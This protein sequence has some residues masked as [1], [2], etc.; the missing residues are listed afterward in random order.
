[1]AGFSKQEIIRAHEAYVATRDRIDAGQ[2]GWD[3]LGDYFTAD[4]TFVDPAWGRIDGRA[5]I[6][7]FF[8]ES[9]RGL[10][11]W[12]FPHEWRAVEGDRLYAGWQNRLPGRRADGRYYQAP[13]MSLFVYAGD[14]RFS[15]E[16]DLSNMAHVL[17]LWKESRYRPGAGFRSP[18]TPIRLCAWLPEEG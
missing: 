3:A 2:L 8:V 6:I 5:K 15:L 4:A 9:M 1:M 14:G 7:A 17:E 10:E 16:H 11:D 12:K 13:G 18:P